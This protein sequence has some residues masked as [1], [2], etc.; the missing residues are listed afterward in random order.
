MFQ[1]FYRRLLAKRLITQTSV[2]DDAES[3]M[4]SKLKEACGAEYT[5]KLQRMIQDTTVSKELSEKYRD[6]KAE[7][8]KK[9][10]D[11]NV[12][13]LMAGSWPQMSGQGINLIMP[14]ELEENAQDFNDFYSNVHKN[15][16]LTWQHNMAKG[17]VVTSYLKNRYV[18]TVS[19]Y[20]LAVL[21]QF[22]EHDSRSLQELI[23][24][25]GIPEEYLVQVLQILLKAKI[26]TCSN[27]ENRLN[28]ESVFKL[29]MGFK[30]YALRMIWYIQYGF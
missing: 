23:D 1:T 29:N 11:Y 13:I 18:L 19:V 26:L 17:E 9:G 7:N 28:A 4:I 30:R 12:Q 8:N 20:Q 27:G 2:S 22:N 6:H 15:R 10:I 25:T 3:S 16:K 21:Q 14:R 24:F 5:T